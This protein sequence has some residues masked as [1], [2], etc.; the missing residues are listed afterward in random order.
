VRARHEAGGPR[1]SAGPGPSGGPAGPQGDQ[2][3]AGPAGPPGISGRVVEEAS[4][5]NSDRVH[6]ALAYCPPG[7]RVIGGGARI[8]GEKDDSAT[9]SG[10]A[11][12]T[13]EPH[14]YSNADTGRFTGWVAFGQ[15]VVPYAGNWRVHVRAICATV[16]S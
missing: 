8:S 10:P 4:T 12:T 16:T 1:G 15:E 2:D 9:L 14:N 6:A 5:R 13:S 7:T 11:L 3:P